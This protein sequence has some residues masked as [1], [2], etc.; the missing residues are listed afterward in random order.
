MSSGLTDHSLKAVGRGDRGDTEESPNTEWSLAGGLLYIALR[1][2]VLLVQQ[3]V[4]AA[5]RTV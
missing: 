5:D 1:Y 3:C 2:A 4:R